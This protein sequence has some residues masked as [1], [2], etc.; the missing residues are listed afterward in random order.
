V[1]YAGVLLILFGITLLVLEVKVASYGLLSAGGIISLLLGS[2][3]LIDSPVPEL[4]VSLSVIL[5]VVAGLA[6]I[7]IFLVR[8]GVAS[9]LRR[10]ATG[11]EGMVGT[12]GVVKAP[13]RRRPPGASRPTVRSGRPPPTRSSPRARTWRSWRSR[14]CG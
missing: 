13:S 9:Q 10:P 4:R 5:P 2:M 6:A 14:G 1:N 7:L 8:L 3:I 12:V 11:A